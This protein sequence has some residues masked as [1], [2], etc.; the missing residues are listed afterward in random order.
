M[1]DSGKFRRT[2]WMAIA[3]VITT[4]DGVP[5]VTYRIRCTL[6]FYF[7]RMYGI[8]VYLI[9]FIHGISIF[10]MCG[11]SVFTYGI[12]TTVIYG[13]CFDIR[14][15]KFFSKTSWIDSSLDIS[16]E[17]LKRTVLHEFQYQTYIIYYFI[18]LLLL[19]YIYFVIIYFILLFYYYTFSYLFSF[20]FVLDTL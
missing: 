1:G 15:V 5:H 13:I 7:Y 4:G 9:V 12:S 6:C 17:M 8:L 11:M 3:T 16:L 2:G 14:Y 10:F 18:Y 19:R 20:A